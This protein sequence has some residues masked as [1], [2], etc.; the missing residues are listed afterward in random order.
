MVEGEDLSDEGG[1]GENSDE[2]GAGSD[3]SMNIGEDADATRVSRF[4]K[5]LESGVSLLTRLSHLR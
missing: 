3:D 2:E 4:A 1:R 5:K